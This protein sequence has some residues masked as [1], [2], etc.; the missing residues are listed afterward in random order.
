MEESKTKEKGFSV[1]EALIILV[2]LLAIGAVGWLVYKDH[3]KTTSSDKTTSSTAIQP[4]LG[5][6]WAS[7]QEGYG[8]VKPTTIFNGG[9]GSG[10]LKNITWQ[11]WGDSKA[12]GHGTGL[13]VSPSDASNADG[14]Q[15]QATVVAFNLGTCKD[16]SS[17][18]AIE[19]Y[20]PQHGQLFSSTTYQNDCTGAYVGESTIGSHTILAPAT[21]PSKTGECGQT[22]T[23]A[24]DGSSGPLTCNS[25]GIDNGDL[26]IDE[27]NDILN[28]YA[29]YIPAVM[30][31]GYNATYAQVEVAVCKD[32]ASGKG[33]S[34]IEDNAYQISALYYG[35]HFS[36]DPVYDPS[37][38][39]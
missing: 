12:T 5:T 39:C 22:V 36:T 33:T 32:G 30:T 28:T 25:V 27:W 37:N 26:N 15:E 8:S 9:D 20:F 19:W 31:L 10:L 11:S 21:V 2:T 35:W 18:N 24:V 1:V 16:K 23:R 13:Y 34:V 17:Y 3:H 29:P 4:V 7:S 6:T 14:T 38:T